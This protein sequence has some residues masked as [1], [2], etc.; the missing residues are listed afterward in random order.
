MARKKK[1]VAQKSNTLP[2]AIAD[3]ATGLAESATSSTDGVNFMK[4]TKF[5]EFLFGA[6]SIEV[7][8]DSEWAVNPAGFGHGWI[9]WG[10]DVHGNDGTMLGEV[11]GPAGQPLPGQPD[12]VEGS[13][14]E[15]RAVQMACVSGE[16]EGTQCLFKSSSI[17]GKKFYAAIVLEV[18][19]KIKAG[20]PAV[21]AII[22]LE[23]D[24]Y[25]H[26]KYGKIFTPDFS[27]VRWQTMDASAAAEE[28]P[29]SKDDAVPEQKPEAKKEE[30]ASPRRRRR[31][32]AA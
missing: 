31:R 30:E 1:E 24:S 11:M 25:K 4:F 12:P 17:G 7:E 21:V 6:D 2:A 23:A 22:T 5:G 19:K 16:D 10:D 32:A 15:Q 8:D 20:D 14:A 3:L 28:A 29:A 27:V 18:V 13:W 26:A 9:A